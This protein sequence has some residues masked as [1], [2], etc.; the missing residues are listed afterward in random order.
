MSMQSEQLDIMRRVKT[1]D[2]RI[3]F[4]GQNDPEQVAARMIE[5]YDQN[6]ALGRHTMT[7]DWCIW[8]IRRD[9]APYPVIGMGRVLPDPE[10]IL[11]RLKAADSRIHGDA[12]LDRMHAEN[13]AMRKEQESAAEEAT[14]LAA[15]AMEW[16]RR[17]MHGYSGRL[18]NV[19]GTKRNAKEK[20]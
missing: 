10:V 4:P 3:A 13:D 6:L 12:I 17:D 7:G 15:E 1:Y 19:R 11:E 20:T 9:E 5:E 18:R 2:P 16:A 8:L 14:N